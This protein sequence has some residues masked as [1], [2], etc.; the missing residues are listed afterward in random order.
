MADCRRIKRKALS[1]D[2]FMAKQSVNDVDIAAWNENSL[3]NIFKEY[4]PDYVF[5]EF[6]LFFK[7]MPDK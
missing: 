4:S 7:L 2:K 6:S 3:L 1:V 5:N